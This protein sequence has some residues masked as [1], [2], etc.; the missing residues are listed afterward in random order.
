VRSAS[1]DVRRDVRRRLRREIGYYVPSLAALFVLV[2]ARTPAG[3]AFIGA[4]AVLL[5]GIMTALWAIERR[6]ALAPR[7][8]SLRDVARRLRSDVEAASRAYFGAFVAM[9]ASAAALIVA[10]VWWR[11]GV[12]V[13]VAVAAAAGIMLCV[14]AVWSGRRY[15]NRMFGPYRDALDSCLRELGEA[16]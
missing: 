2:D 15:V 12:H 8:G 1:A 4:I 13:H 7:D 5:G 10:A 14:W 9:V 3:W 11:R 16:G 6:L